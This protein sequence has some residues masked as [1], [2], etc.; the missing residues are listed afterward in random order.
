LREEFGG[1]VGLSVLPLRLVPA[2]SSSSDNQL[3]IQVNNIVYIVLQV[4]E[5]LLSTLIYGH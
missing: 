3:L 4:C 2:G 1:S 5:Y